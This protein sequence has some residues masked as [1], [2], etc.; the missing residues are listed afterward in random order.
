M[1]FCN[2][3]DLDVHCEGA[4]GHFEGCRDR[5]KVG[6]RPV[7]FEQAL[8]ARKNP[9]N[10]NNN[11]I[12]LPSKIGLHVWQEKMPHGTVGPLKQS[13]QITFSS[14]T[15]TRARPECPEG[16]VADMMIII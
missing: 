13:K 12:L 15:L 3:G 2:F 9:L 10:T 7:Q 16:T 11:D 14:G 5:G 4:G 8:L 1:I 6:A